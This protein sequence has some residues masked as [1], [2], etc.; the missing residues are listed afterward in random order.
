M[1]HDDARKI[2]K[3]LSCNVGGD[4]DFSPS[5]SREVWEKEQYACYY[6]YLFSLIQENRLAV[7]K[8]AKRTG[9][10]ERRL[11]E[12]LAFRLKRGNRAGQLF[13]HKDSQCYVCNARSQSTTNREPICLRCLQLVEKACMEIEEDEALL[14]GAASHALSPEMPLVEMAEA[15]AVPAPSDPASMVVVAPE[16]PPSLADASASPPLA[17]L[18]SLQQELDAY[19]RHFGPLPAAEAMPL[20]SGS[21]DVVPSDTSENASGLMPPDA[22]DEA[23]SSSAT[24]SDEVQAAH[25]AEQLLQ[26]LYVD[27]RELSGEAVDLTEL[28]SQILPRNNAPLRHF[29]FQRPKSYKS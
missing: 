11:D 20:A 15:Q 4:T 5:D 13:G 6:N 1:K 8:V 2:D 28:I 18:Q 9:L 7:E 26:I 21:Q 29:G 16:E 24:T 27:D 3:H 19:K 17:S 23:L 10:K 22:L 12:A 25:E 14:N